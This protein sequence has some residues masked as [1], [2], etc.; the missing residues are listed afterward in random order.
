VYYTY[1][2]PTGDVSTDQM[3]FID[4]L[5]E[6]YPMTNCNP[7][8]LSMDVDTDLASIPLS[9]V[10]NKDIVTTYAKL[11]GEMLYISINTVPEIMYSLS[12]LSEAELISVTSALKK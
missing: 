10:P 7:Y 8:V 5:L 9:D 1:D 3:A 6:Q 4:K 11:V 12:T 2:L